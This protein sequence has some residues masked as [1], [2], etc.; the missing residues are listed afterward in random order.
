[1]KRINFKEIEAGNE[2][3]GINIDSKDNYTIF[4]PKYYLKSEEIKKI[5]ENT[6]NKLKKLF[7]AWNIYQK[8]TNNSLGAKFNKNNNIYDITISLDIIEDFVEHGLYIEQEDTSKITNTGKMNFKKTINMCHPLYTKQGP[9]YLDYITD[10][11]K[12]NDQNL[13]RLIQSIVINEISEDFGW[14]IGFNFK[15][16][17]Q[18]RVKLNKKIVFILNQMLTQSFNSRKINLIKLLINYININSKGLIDGKELF[19]GMASMFWQDMI[20]YVVGNVSK[21]ELRKFFNVKHA[22]VS[23][24]SIEPLSSLKP[25]SVYKDKYNIILIDS[26][27][28]INQSLPDNDDINK[29]IIYFLKAYETFQEYEHFGNC[30]IFPTD[31]YTYKSNKEAK[32]DI[33][34]E[35]K[36]LSINLIY[37]NVNEV[38]EYYISKKKNFEIIGELVSSN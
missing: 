38:L 9:V 32:F 25:D 11:K 22:Y 16:P 7:K 35:N 17:I 30:F 26:K 28:Y 8:R 18:K 6:K 27:Y 24:N 14:I 1:M 10:A 23:D 29:Q 31:T 12:P 20:N 5:N 19:V 33:E 34:V 4:I 36:L 3:I 37:A 15:L 21:S 2:K 13:I